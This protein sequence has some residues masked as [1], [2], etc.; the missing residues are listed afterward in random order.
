LCVFS[1]CCNSYQ[2]ILWGVIKDVLTLE[3]ETSIKIQEN[4]MEQIDAVVD[5]A[6]DV[7]Q[8]PVVKIE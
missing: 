6:A 7:K 4:H 3:R 8:T 2:G 1:Y 5:N